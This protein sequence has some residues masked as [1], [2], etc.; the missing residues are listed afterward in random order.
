M[1]YWFFIFMIV[2]V[3]CAAAIGFAVGRA[4]DWMGTR[5]PDLVVLVL[6]AAIAFAPLLVTFLGYL[7]PPLTRVHGII[8]LIAFF[9]GIQL[10]GKIRQPST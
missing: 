8:W 6:V 2:T 10:S 3:V 4:C 9:A 7:P 5:L 1:S